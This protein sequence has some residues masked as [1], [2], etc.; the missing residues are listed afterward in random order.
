MAMRPEFIESTAGKIADELARRGISPD[1]RVMITIEPDD[2]LARALS[3][4]HG[5]KA[6]ATRTS[7]A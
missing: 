3:P 1:Q 6:G 5:P 4:G 2:W 7:I